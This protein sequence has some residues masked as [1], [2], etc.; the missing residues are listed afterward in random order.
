MKTKQTIIALLIL[1][2]A[3]AFTGKNDEYTV[4]T[5]QSKLTWVGRK[6]TGEHTGN[7]S[8]ADGK[9]VADGKTLKA[10]SFKIDMASITNQDIEDESYRQKLL[11]H[12]KSDDF[13]STDK[14]AQSTFVITKV[15]PGA[16]NQYQIKGNLTIKGITKEIE[17]PATVQVDE[18]QVI[19]KAKVVVDRTQYD[20]KYGSGSFFDNLG[21]KAID[22]NF[23]LNVNLVA[24]KGISPRQ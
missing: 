2:T 9:L 1:V 12:L 19:A 3:F 13:F 20:I 4:N 8:I 5:D 11:G 17:F 6:V 7:I 14:H 23:E 24:Q 16:G 22:N 21:D 15:T 18:K 10:G